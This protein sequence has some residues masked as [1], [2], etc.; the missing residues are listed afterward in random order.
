MQQ[1]SDEPR[2]ASAKKPYHP[3]ALSALGSVSDLTRTQPTGE[4]L[5]GGSGVNI[6]VS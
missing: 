6:Y 5:D 1:M 3:P 4:N 2:A